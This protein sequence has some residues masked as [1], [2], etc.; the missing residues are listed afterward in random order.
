VDAS[1]KWGIILLSDKKQ[2]VTFFDT[3]L[4]DGEQTP[5]ISLTAAKKLMIAVAIDGLGVKVIEAGFACISPGEKEAI[6]IISGAGLNAEICSAARSVRKDVDAAIEANVDSVNIIIPTS[7]LHLR[8]KLE[9]TREQVLEITTDV[10]TY[11]KSFGIKVEICLEDGSRTEFEYL[12]QVIQ[13]AIDAGVDRVTPCDTVGNLTPES[14][15]EYYGGLHREFPKLV[16]GVHCHNDFGLA[17]ANSLAAIAA[18]A[19]HFHGTINGLGERAGNA[20]LEEMAVALKLLYGIESGINFQNLQEVSQI[21]SRTTG[22]LVQVNKAIVG[23]NAFAHESGI[24]THAIL[25]DPSTYEIINPSMVGAVRKIATGKHSGSAGLTKSL[26]EMGFT[27]LRGQFEAI[28]TRVKDLGDKSIQISDT[29]LYEIAEEITAS[30]AEKPL[31]IEEVIVTTGNKIT[32]TAS[33]KLRQDGHIVV[34]A[35]TGNGPVDA[36]INAINKAIHPEQRVHLDVYHVE[37]ITGGTDARV[38]VVIN[39]RQGEKLLSS[40]GINEDIVLASVDAYI[41]GVNLFNSMNKRKQN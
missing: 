29:D 25:K 23:A 41:K 17:V 24:H 18:G 35:A 31:I 2:S 5:G 3:T 39:L 27:P 12:K 7:D 30:Q 26:T 15:Y 11:A 21:V 14:S 10:I 38:E 13:H 33:V 1:D 34:E 28:Y 4:R 9:K 32:P 22:I 37:A 19:T 6:K 36:T 8:K 16:L 40:R 20:S